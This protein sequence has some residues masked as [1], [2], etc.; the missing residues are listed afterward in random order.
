MLPNY[1]FP[2]EGIKLKSILARLPENGKREE[3]GDNLV[4][5]EYVRSASSA[6]SEFALGQTFYANGR[7]VIIDRL[8]LNKQDLSTFGGFVKTARTLNFRRR[9]VNCLAAQ[10]VAMICGTIWGLLMRP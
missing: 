1:A 8:D 6:L 5:H 2:E 7:E 3:N 10:D 4:T 9:Q